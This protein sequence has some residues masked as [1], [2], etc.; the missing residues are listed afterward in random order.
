M[1]KFLKNRKGLA[2][3]PGKLLILLILG[4]IYILVAPVLF[5]DGEQYKYTPL[6]NMQ[7]NAINSSA[8]KIQHLGG[9]FLDFNPSKTLITLNF[10]GEEQRLE[11]SGLKILGVGDTGFLSLK[12]EYGNP[13]NVVPGTIATF[14]VT[15]LKSRRL[16]FVQQVYFGKEAGTQEKYPFQPELSGSYYSDPEQMARKGPIEDGI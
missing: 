6:I 10:G 8:L 16:I 2:P 4:L 1:E 13:I 7:V 11:A 9:D 3:L 14:K 5:E 12:S 15:D